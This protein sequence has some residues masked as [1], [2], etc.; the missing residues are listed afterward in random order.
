MFSLFQSKKTKWKKKLITGLDI[1][2]PGLEGM[3]PE[4]LAMLLDQAV[5]IKDSSLMLLENND[6]S[7]AYWEDPLMIDENDAL[8]RLDFWHKWMLGWLAEGVMGQS[9]VAS[10]NIYFF[11][12][13]TGIYPELRVKGKKMWKNLSRGFKLCTIFDSKIDIPKGFEKFK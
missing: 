4:E 6:P 10:F 5:K 9:K 3:D 8:E 13:G 11:S 7:K 1:Y 12:L 2:I